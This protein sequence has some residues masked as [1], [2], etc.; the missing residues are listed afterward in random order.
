MTTLR[1]RCLQSDRG[2]PKR[3]PVEFVGETVWAWGLTP[4]QRDELEESRLDQTAPKGTVRVKMTGFRLKV[5]MMGTRDS[6][7]D[8]APLTFKAGDETMYLHKFPTDEIDRV[9]T[10]I[11]Q[12]SGMDPNAKDDA[13]KNSTGTDGATS[14][15]ASP[16]A[17]A[18]PLPS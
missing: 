2:K 9:V 11:L 1:D 12:L 5:F 7:E 3:E 13:K 17:S 18:A 15:S 6:G 16:A 4:D 10:K 14:S 8:N